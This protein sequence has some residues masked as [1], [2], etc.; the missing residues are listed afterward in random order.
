MRHSGSMTPTSTAARDD[1]AAID[2]AFLL[3]GSLHE[4][5]ER[6][7]GV[8]ALARATDLSKS[9]AYRVLSMLERNG[10]VDKVGTLY[11]VG[12]GLQR[13]TSRD[14]ASHSADQMRETITPFLMD[15]YAATGASVHLAV[16]KNDRVLYLNRIYGHSSTSCRV[17]IG[18]LAPAHCTSAG[19]ILLAHDPTA[20]ERIID[21]GLPRRTER[22]ITDAEDF[23][24]ELTRI[25]SH[26]TAVDLGESM[27][28]VCCTAITVGGRGTLPR[29]AISVAA[30]KA[31]DLVGH[32]QLLRR[33]RPHIDNA[34]LRS[35]H[36]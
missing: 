3:L 32:G 8:S 7:A 19:K 2:K 28:Q 23:R 35:R 12:A 22:T 10:A 27:P 29:M 31:S 17:R 25:R 20:S 34:L 14:T 30:R 36:G 11:H 16:L 6:G 15:I 21:R 4:F 24:Q 13:M 1:R 33:I 9:T 26:G 18:H 5:G